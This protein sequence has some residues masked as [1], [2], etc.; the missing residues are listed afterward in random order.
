MT[1]PGTITP[2]TN[3]AL[4]DAAEKY[5][6]TTLIPAYLEGADGFATTYLGE[7]EDGLKTLV[8]GDEEQLTVSAEGQDGETKVFVNVDLSPPDGAPASIVEPGFYDENGNRNSE[9]GK[10]ARP[11]VRALTEVEGQELVMDLHTLIAKM[12]TDRRK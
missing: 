4:S 2:Q 3:T 6:R 9:T 12:P 1:Y 10:F 5:R 7:R 11:I 8:T